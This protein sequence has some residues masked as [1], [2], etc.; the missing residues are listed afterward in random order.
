[1]PGISKTTR[2]MFPTAVDINL[3]DEKEVTFSPQ[4]GDKPIKI[5]T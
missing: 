2:D 1:L 4:V 5:R 3:I